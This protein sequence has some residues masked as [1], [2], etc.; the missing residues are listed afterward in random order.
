[1]NV[2]VW[3]KRDLRVTDHPSLTLAAGLGP[4][5]PVYIA[6]PQAWAQPD[7][8]ARHWD[9]V[10]EAL[11]SLRGDLAALGAP[12]VV[13]VGETVR[14]LAR[15]CKQHAIT[16]IVSHAETGLGRDR[17]WDVARD[18]LVAAWAAEAGIDW[19]IVPQGAGCAEG[20][21]AIPAPRALCGVAGAEPGVIP[22]ARALRLVSDPCPH[23][24]TGGRAQADALLESFLAQ[25]GLG[26]RR[27]LSSALLA[28]RGC[29]R[30]SP[31]LA[32]GILSGRMVAQ[33]VAIQQAAR[34]GAGWAADLR[35]FGARLALRDQSTA[36]RD[37][38]VAGPSHPSGPS[39]G[40]MQAWAQGQT[41]YPYLDASMRYLMASGWLNFPARAMLVSFS[42]H[43]LGLDWRGVGQVLAR[44]FTDYDP[45]I[46]WPQVQG[47]AGLAGT[48]RSLNPVRMGLAQDPTGAFTRRWVPELAGVPDGFLQTP[49][50]WSGGQAILGRR[51]P[52]PVV[53]LGKATRHD[54]GVIR[55]GPRATRKLEGP[56]ATRKPAGQLE[57]TF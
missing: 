32:Q 40:L 15:L 36:L 18:R 12:L 7:A 22:P 28:E 23:R 9:F 57:M 2:L 37:D 46:H 5:L 48:Q 21:E 49:W 47:H 10:A 45:G 34:P 3:Y 11:A 8:A 43:H 4:V 39:D 44:R 51:Y 55:Q 14:V 6:D 17:G 24:Q 27:A 13:R 38:A 26:Y 19:T 25:R 1:M 20:A 30:L 16:H 41:G 50:R 33:A 42:C 29:S 35:G 52:E 53:D 31:Y 54:A 56:R